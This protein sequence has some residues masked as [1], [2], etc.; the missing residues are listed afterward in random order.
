MSC[1]T[2]EW[3]EVSGYNILR[4]IYNWAIVH[5]I[6]KELTPKFIFVT[7]L[8]P[9]AVLYSAHARMQA[10][11]DKC[12]YD[13]PERDI[14][15]V[16]SEC[17]LQNDAGRQSSTTS[18]MWLIKG[19]Y[20]PTSAVVIP[21]YFVRP[22]QGYRDVCWYTT[23]SFTIIGPLSLLFQTNWNQMTL[24]A[25]F[26]T[27]KNLFSPVTDAVTSLLYYGVSLPHLESGMLRV[28]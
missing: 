19:R 7:S 22:C 8:G 28:L 13:V 18:R 14:Y 23:L 16:M 27:L 1:L 4:R 26:F 6:L 2:W 5:Y 3:P 20:G 24:L 10:Q 11:C 12:S 9:I 25:S 21:S 17:R 15:T